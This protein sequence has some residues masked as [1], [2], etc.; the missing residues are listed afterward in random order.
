MR[1]PGLVLATDLPP[2]QPKTWDRIIGK[3]EGH[4]SENPTTSRRRFSSPTG[5]LGIRRGAS[6]R[7]VRR[8]PS[9]TGPCGECCWNGLPN[10]PAGIPGA[11]FA[12][13]YQ[14][15]ARSGYPSHPPEK[16][17]AC[18]ADAPQ[19]S[20]PPLRAFTRAGQA[21]SHLPLSSASTTHGAAVDS[22]LVAALIVA[23]ERAI[24]RLLLRPARSGAKLLIG[25]A[26]DL[27][28]Q[29]SELIVEN[30]L[31]RQLLIVLH[32]S[33]ER[34]RLHRDERVLLLARAQQIR[35]WRHALRVASPEMPLPL[36]RQLLA[37]WATR[38]GPA[39]CT[40]PML[41]GGTAAIDPAYAQQQLE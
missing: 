5:L 13:T 29:R 28:R 17:T 37:R 12:T 39:Q 18:W 4:T 36:P 16:S 19:T 31:L 41:T 40:N 30:A 14:S 21:G 3:A 15:S 9:G 35:R 2:Y 33:I 34:S 25:A 20:L 6:G 26:G 7:H 10:K 1:C 22:N 27:T 23:L 32:R 24:P 38:P 8:L 11:M